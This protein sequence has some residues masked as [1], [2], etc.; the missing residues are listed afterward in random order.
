MMIQIKH[1]ILCLSSVGDSN[2]GIF[3]K[4]YPSC[5]FFVSGRF[6]E[7]LKVTVTSL[8]RKRLKQSKQ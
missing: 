2:C 7:R 8:G 6:Q 3:V 5:Y 1:L 4:Q